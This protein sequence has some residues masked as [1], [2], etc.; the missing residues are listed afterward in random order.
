ML[1]IYCLGQFRVQVDGQPVAIPSRPAQSLFA[2]LALH[3]GLVHRREKLAGLL[4]PDS[5][6]ENARAYLRQALWHI[7]KTLETAGVSW[8]HYL[9]ID[10]LQVVFHEQADIFLDTVH[11]LERN[12]EDVWS[13]ADLI[14]RIQLYKGELLPGFYDEWIILCREQLNAAYNQKM[15]LLLERLECAQ[16]WD[17]LL[18]WSECWISFG[19]V[20]EPAFRGLMIAHAARGDQSALSAAFH[21]CEKAFEEDLGLPPPPDLQEICHVLLR[22]E[23]P[24]PYEAAEQAFHLVE[25]FPPAPGESPYKGLEYFDTADTHLFFGRESLTERLVQHLKQSHFLALVGASGSGKSSIAR[26]GVIPALA[27]SGWQV[28]LMTP[29]DHPLQ[30]LAKSL[31][32]ELSFI[33][34]ALLNPFTLGELLCKRAKKETTVCLLVIDQFEELFS[35]CQD[36]QEKK[37]FIDNLLSANDCAREDH[38]A[39]MI[40][41]R[42]DF[43]T[44]YGQYPA[45][46]RALSSQQEYIGPMTAEELRSAI[47][48]PAR[49]GGWQFEPG[50]VD[51]ILREVKNEAGALPLLSHALLETWQRR[52][53]HWMTLKGYAEA[54][55]VHSAIARTAD[56][57]F[58]RQLNEQQ[59]EIARNIFL[60][61]SDYDEEFI[62]MRRRAEI[63]EFDLESGSEDQVAHVLDILSTARLITISEHA[64]EIAHEA[65]IR[66]WPLLHQWLIEDRVRVDQHHHL[67][68]AAHRWEGLGR[69][70]V[71]VYRGARLAQVLEWS[72]ENSGLLNHL[73]LEF[74][75]AS[76]DE[77]QREQHEKE[78]QQQRE[79]EAA[80]HLAVSEKQRA[81]ENIRSNRRLRVFAI[82]ISLIFLVTFITAWIAV[83]QRNR[84]N[85]SIHLAHSRELISAALTQQELDPQLSI[86]LALEAVKESQL[87][88]A[89]VSPRMA[90]ALHQ[91]V[92]ASKQ[93]LLLKIPSGKVNAAAFSRDGQLVAAGSMDGPIYLLDDYTGEI[94][95]TLT[96]HE[97]GIFWVNFHPNGRW[98]A[99]TGRDHTV[100]MWDLR[101]G[102]PIWIY[103]DILKVAYKVTFHPDG[104]HT[105]FVKKGGVLVVVDSYTGE[106]LYESRCE[107]TVLSFDY[108]P[109]GSMIAIAGMHGFIQFFD[110]ATGKELN[111]IDLGVDAVMNNYLA[112]SPDGKK[113][114]VSTV[115]GH[116]QLWDLDNWSLIWSKKPAPGK[117]L[118]QINFS[119]DGQF[120]VTSGG[121]PGAL[122]W[123]AA[124]GEFVMALLGHT[125]WTFNAIFNPAGDQILSSSIDGSTIVWDFLPKREAVLIPTW[126]KPDAPDDVRRQ[127]DFSP[128]GL[129]I[130]AGEGNEGA[131]GIWDAFTGARLRTLQDHQRY[132][133]VTIVAFH[134]DGYTLMAVDLGGYISVWDWASGRR[135]Q[136]WNAHQGVIVSARYSHS[137]DTIFS[138]GWDRQFKIWDA[139]T[140]ALSDN[141]KSFVGYVIGYL[142]V[143]PDD[144]TVVLPADFGTLLLM[145]VTTGQVIREFRGQATTI[146][147]A[148]VSHD[149][150]RIASLGVE[151]DISIWDLKRAERIEHF[152][153]KLVTATEI[154]FSPDGRRLAVIGPDPTLRLLDVETGE[155][156]LLI[157]NLSATHVGG[158]TFSPDGKRLAVTSQDGIEIF[159]VELEDII[160]LAQ[161]RVMRSFTPLECQQFNIRSDCSPQETLEPTVVVVTKKPKERRLACYLPGFDGL[162]LDYFNRK[163]FLGM[164]DAAKQL[165][166]DTMALEPFA[167]LPWEMDEFLQKFY[168]SQCDLIILS[169]WENERLAEPQDHLDQR[170]LFIEHYTPN[171]WDHVWTTQYQI[172]QPSFLAGYLAAAMTE[173]GRVG[174]FSGSPI[175]ATIDFMHGFALGIDAYNQRHHAA[176]ELLG[177][178]TDNRG[179]GGIFTGFYM[180]EAAYAA[181]QDLMS[182]G[183]DIIYPIIDEATLLGAS[184]AASSRKGVLLIGVDQDWAESFPEYASITLTSVVKHLDKPVF[185]A[186]ESVTDGTFTGGPHICNLENGCVSLAPFHAFED[187]I[188]DEI[189]AE[190]EQLRQDIIAGKVKTR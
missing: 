178:L 166:W 151:G 84:S 180:P 79:L 130:A 28:S 89:P 50:L 147:F 68:E 115:M 112:F 170:F 159:L 22:G 35:L 21:R 117:T 188:P 70:P 20:P 158:V 113:M 102:E 46:R 190:L 160:Q 66:E 114:A 88:Q 90:S 37:A 137:G 96:G 173:T 167:T 186:M 152:D 23:I 49:K 76:I 58:N 149:G 121:E 39:L 40:I 144:Q 120:L 95:Q 62:G 10:E 109:D 7:R 55:G 100:R 165:D 99:S 104:S 97:G 110:A 73:E 116:M 177:R 118:T 184:K 124:T 2:Y 169:T 78:Q 150:Q 171:Q 18:Y 92:R 41:L 5:T 126:Q 61:L 146:W 128:D 174:M 38:P 182:R 34:S 179:S 13:L 111:K 64:I 6:D 107:D 19:Q 1:R 91:A 87:A 140:G 172:D 9:R 125:A 60:R 11:L 176:V 42:A 74:L 77:E 45:L 85:R 31:D 36:E 43:Y 145:D 83:D 122:V 139:D 26:A 8:K 164:L 48:E 134:P 4:W 30:A 103:R 162:D 161:S 12:G 157:D 155:E 129:M 141:H 136:S 81:E 54:G 15:R 175:Q 24:T 33:R 154:V 105:A 132:S 138:N 29:T 86:L 135:I 163:P 101:T 168:Q 181:T 65:L 80:Q 47:E 156:T 119:P 44:H 142:A 75:K 56:V 148:A 51:L 3:S 108:S 53:G 27:P 133:A 71:E 153:T 94:I 59:Q 52:S 82:G 143:T 14:E 25:S 17:D 98:M 32:V 185:W 106:I 127:G 183:A 72:Q 63:S 16:K 187:Q 189:K 57:V 93:R 67:T 123:E 131:I 69:D